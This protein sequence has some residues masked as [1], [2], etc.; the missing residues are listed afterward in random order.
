M[1]VCNI[2]GK[3]FQN[4]RALVCHRISKHFT[5][6]KPNKGSFK[7]G[8]KPWNT[9]IKA[10]VSEES[11]KA[12]ISWVKQHGPWNKKPKIEKKCP[13]CGK[14]FY[15][16]PS[17]FWR[18]TCSY[19]CSAKLR[20][21]NPE[22]RKRHGEYIRRLLRENP[23]RLRLQLARLQSEEA[24]RKMQ[25]TRKRQM[26]ENPELLKRCLTCRRPNKAEE[27]LI[28]LFKIH[29]IP[30]KYCGDG[31]VVIGG[32]NP[33]FI[34]RNGRKQLIELFGYF[35]HKN[36]DPNERIKHFKKYGFDTLI[37]WDYELKDE[38]SVLEKV[39][40]FMGGVLNA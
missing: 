7:K 39:K 32:K 20:A 16:K 6:H 12:L 9:G 27:K 11:V 30:F 38:N 18:K 28:E 33:D 5:K 14:V 31:D 25:E 15:V 3:A 1:D 2:C 24:R 13:V 26:R 21:S 10:P 22:W 17:H 4:K 35:W 19:E 34:N 23:E 36:D 40:A 37:I 29:N 8:H